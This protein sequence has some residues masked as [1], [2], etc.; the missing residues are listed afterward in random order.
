MFSG[1]SNEKC[2]HEL[3]FLD[4]ESPDGGAVWEGSVR[5]RSLAGGSVSLGEGFGSP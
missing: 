3:M 1:D 2:P 5:V 4:T